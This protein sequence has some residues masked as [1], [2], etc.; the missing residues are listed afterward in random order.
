V[1]IIADDARVEA[2]LEEM[3]TTVVALVEALRVAE[4][5]KVHAAGEVLELGEDDDVEV[6]RHLAGG[7][8]V[9]APPQRGEALEL[10]EALVVGVVAV[11]LLAVDATCGHVV[12]GDVRKNATR[13]ATHGCERSDRRQRP[14]IRSFARVRNAHVPGTVPQTW[15]ENSRPR[16][17]RSALHGA[18]ET[19]MSR[20]LSPGHGR[21]GHGP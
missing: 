4:V 8:D 13:Q 15:P 18:A 7:E 20:G 1:L 19:D 6:V 21:D 14:A 9:P 5:Q 2:I 12:N 10:G 16:P 3:P 17:R 11:D